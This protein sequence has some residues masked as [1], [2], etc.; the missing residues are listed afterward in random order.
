MAVCNGDKQTIRNAIQS[1]S[2]NYYVYIL[3]RPNGLPFYVGKGKNDRVFQH[4]MDAVNNPEI[5]SYKLNIIRA[6]LKEN[7]KLIYEIDS[8]HQEEL[9]SLERERHLIQSIGRHDLR[10]GS[11]ANMTD[12]GEGPANFS[13]ETKQKHRDTL[14]GIDGDDQRSIANRF[15]LKLKNVESVTIKPEGSFKVKSLEP[16]PNQRKNT[17]RMAATLAASA[18]A[19]RVMLEDG[20]VLPRRMML[21]DCQYIIENGVGR[22]MLKSGIA[23]LITNNNSKYEAFKLAHGA[24]NYI[25][26][27]L[28]KDILLDAGVLMPDCESE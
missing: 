26:S 17:P 16:H 10:T 12:G 19:N 13:E 11:L 6:I 28:G 25:I 18:I 23:T 2:G 3:K 4:E 27:V 22:D 21:E 5:K 24:T 1:A 7:A 20:C 14:Y 8:F 9:D 15:F